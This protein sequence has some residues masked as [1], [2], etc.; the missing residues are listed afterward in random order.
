MLGLYYNKVIAYAEHMPH[1]T[2]NTNYFANPQFALNPQC[3][4]EGPS[5]LRCTISNC[6]HLCMRVYVVK[7]I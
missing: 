5:R 3:H 1:N 7:G 6:V 2:G 4:W